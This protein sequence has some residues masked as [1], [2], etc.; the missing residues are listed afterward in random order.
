MTINQQLADIRKA[1]IEK[2]NDFETAF[3]KFH[4]AECRNM[5]R[6]GMRDGNNDR[7]HPEADGLCSTEREIATA[8]AAQ[9]SELAIDFGGFLEQVSPQRGIVR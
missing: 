4:T 2:V 5:R 9:V 7:P 6:R 8:Y 1:F 3:K